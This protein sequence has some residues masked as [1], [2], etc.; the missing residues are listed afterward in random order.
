MLEGIDKIKKYSLLNSTKSTFL[1]ET[2]VL[3][4]D[5]NTQ[6]DYLVSS[7]L[8]LTFNSNNSGAINLI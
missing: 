8:S 5:K 2:R 3:Y 7:A 6:S 1:I 4:P